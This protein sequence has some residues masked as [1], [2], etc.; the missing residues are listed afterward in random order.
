MQGL[1][2]STVDLYAKQ[3]FKILNEPRVVQQNPA[4]LPTHQQVEIA[5][6]LGLA[7]GY[8][9]EHANVVSAAALGQAQDFIPPVCSQCVQREDVFLDLYL[10]K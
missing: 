1:L 6:F 4:R 2:R 7:A 3:L 8:G 9:A 5:A 10:R